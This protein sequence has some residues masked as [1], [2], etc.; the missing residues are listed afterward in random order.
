VIYFCAQKNRRTL[1][2]ARPPLNGIDYLEIADATDQGVLLV[3]FLR[4]A[5]PLAL[6]PQNIVIQG[7]ES[8]TNIVVLAASV[9]PQAPNTL[10]VT[11]DRAGD[12]STYTLAL[13][14]NATTDEPP[15][16]V[17]PG[18][19][20]AALKTLLR[21]ARFNVMDGLDVYIDDYSK[22]DPI[23]AEWLGQLKQLERLGHYIEPEEKP[24]NDEKKV[25]TAQEAL[26]REPQEAMQEAPVSFPQKAPSP[27]T[28]GEDAPAPE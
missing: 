11:V 28:A 25:E 27:D 9:D 16:G 6:T 8:V 14:A 17:D 7:G 1:V 26:P 20:R 15:P 13:I 3:T 4:P 24:E 10:R 21:D 2:L 12:F 19:K 18:L 23:P 5:A 22:P